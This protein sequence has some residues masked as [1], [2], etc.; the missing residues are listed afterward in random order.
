M[1]FLIQHPLSRRRFLQGTS[2]L[3]A[4]MVLRPVVG[5]EDEAADSGTGEIRLALFSDPHIPADAGEAYRGFKPVENLGQVLPQIVAAQP[6]AAIL[7]GDAA[8]LQGLIPDYER[9]KTML[10]PLAEECPVAIALGN[11]DDRANFRK[12]FGNVHPGL[13]PVTGKHVMVLEWLRLRVIVLD[14][15]LFVNETP[16]LLGKAQR[17]WLDHFLQDSD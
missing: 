9:L 11:H 15:L 16:G 10:V 14:S 8:R 1:P 6:L 12:V 2:L 13:Q 7:C 17:L 4:G 3:A 5:A